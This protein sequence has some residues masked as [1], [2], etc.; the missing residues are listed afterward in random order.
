MTL[1]KHQDGLGIYGARDNN[2]AMV[3]K[4]SYDL[5]SDAKKFW[6]DIMK[7]KYLLK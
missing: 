6:V 2:I 5:I 7:N 1:P 3:N 4:L